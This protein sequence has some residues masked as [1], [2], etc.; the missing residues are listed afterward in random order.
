MRRN[1]DVPASGADGVDLSDDGPGQHNL[2]RSEGPRSRATHVARMA[3]FRRARRVV[4]NLIDAT[5]ML[6]ASLTEAGSGKALSDRPAFEPYWRKPAVRNLRGDDGNGGIIRSPIRAIVLPDPLASTRDSRNCGRPA[7][8]ARAW[9]GPPPFRSATA[10]T[11]QE[12][13]VGG[14]SESNKRPPMRKWEVVA[15]S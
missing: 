15:P 12:D 4:A 2:D 8:S 6:G 11:K 1:R 5:G 9:M 3:V 14:G 7:P 13:H 10:N